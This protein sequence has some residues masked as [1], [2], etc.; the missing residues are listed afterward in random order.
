MNYRLVKEGANRFPAQ[1]ED[2]QSVLKF[3]S[4][5][6]DK[7][8]Y[9]GNEFA[10]MGGSA[11][12][13]L[14]MLY[15]YGYDAAHQVKTV[16]DLWGP[17]DLADASVRADNKDADSKVVNLLGVSDPQAQVCRD[18]SPWYRLTKETG[19]PTILFHGGEDP[20][21]N[22]SQAEKLYKKLMDLGIPTQYEKYPHEK[23]GVGPAA[24]A[25]VFAK[26]L[27]W[28]A[29]YYPSGLT[30]VSPATSATTMSTSPSGSAGNS[31]VNQPSGVTNQPQGVTGSSVNQPHA[32][33]G[34]S[35]IKSVPG[36]SSV[37]QPSGVTT[38]GST[39]PSTTY[40]EKLGFPKGAKVIIFHVDDA[41]MS[42]NSNEGAINSIEKGVA[43]STS[44]MMP[45]PWA[46]SFA[47]YAAEQ[48]Y[49][50]GLHLTLTAEWHHYRW[51]PLAGIKQV[52][53]LTD[54]EWCFWPEPQDV[55]QHASA[56]EVEMEIRAQLARALAVGLHPTH[57]DSHMGT[58]FA[59][60]AYLERYIKV[61]VE[62]HIPVMFPGG[63]NKMLLANSKQALG[64]TTAIGEMIWKAGLPV[65]DDLITYSGEWKPQPVNGVVTP[66]A[67]AKYKVAKFEETIEN[68]Q[69]GV[70][71]YIVHSTVVTDDFRHISGSGDSRNADM[72]SMMDPEFKTWL[73][74]KGIILT[75]WRELMQRREQVK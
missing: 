69:P 22:V 51:G 16:I 3:L 4:G 31:S 1:I 14:A 71:M 2:V 7:Y 36:G 12:A 38:S 70:A 54:T 18:A 50:A 64:N 56:D 15:A 20:L 6:A 13:H 21:V 62:N 61:G 65:L 8:R 9:D 29:K 33:T 27:V 66:E 45:C 47:K 46:A 25:D 40:A 35:L 55:I 34:S 49:D 52:P 67:Y 10:L 39:A 42:I 5:Y 72:L 53:G 24:A 73:Q 37:N 60:Q 30:S 17:T 58:L 63:N 19:V 48:G 23:H 68:M 28:L 44:V 75:T 59:S 74:S 43:T 32:T 57:L 26:T 41:G 11:G